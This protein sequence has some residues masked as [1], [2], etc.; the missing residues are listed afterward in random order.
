M[1][2]AYAAASFRNDGGRSKEIEQTNRYT[3]M[4][5]KKIIAFLHYYEASISMQ[6]DDH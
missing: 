6:P 2:A 5:C 3:C 4:Q 1:N